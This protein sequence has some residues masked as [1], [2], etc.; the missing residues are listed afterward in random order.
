LNVS[1][2]VLPSLFLLELCSHCN[3]NNNNNNSK[4]P[5]LRFEQVSTTTKQKQASTE[6]PSLPFNSRCYYLVFGPSSTTIWGWG[7]RPV[8]DGY[9]IFNIP[10]W[11]EYIYI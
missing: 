6:L 4:V 5:D 8:L 9:W 7:F 1:F 11:Y 3:N 2:R 10:I